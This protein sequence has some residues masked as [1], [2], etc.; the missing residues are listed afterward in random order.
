MLSLSIPPPLSILQSPLPLPLYLS[1]PSIPLPPL[2]LSSLSPSLLCYVRTK[3]LPAIFAILDLYKSDARIVE[4]S[5]RCLRFILRCLRSHANAII[6]QIITVVGSMIIDKCRWKK[7]LIFFL[8]FFIQSITLYQQCHHSCFLYLGSIIVDE[9]GPQPVNHA[10][11]LAMT[12]SFVTVSFGLLSGPTGL[13]DH[14]DTIDDMFRL[15]ARYTPH[16]NGTSLIRTLWNK[17]LS[18]IRT[19]SGVPKIALVCKLPLKRGHLYNQGI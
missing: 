14:P 19:H 8:I 3:V 1:P 11:L 5:C 7:I 6:D 18:I 10:G 16:Y 13:I 12:E 2:S 4:R 15:C 17:D 9:F